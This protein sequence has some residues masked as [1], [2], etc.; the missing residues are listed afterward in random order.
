MSVDRL[1][2]NAF[3]T[4]LESIYTSVMDTITCDGGDLLGIQ[5][6]VL[7]KL[8][9]K[10][11]SAMPPAV[12]RLLRFA[13][14]L[15]VLRS[16]DRASLAQALEAKEMD[17]AQLPELHVDLLTAAWL[18]LYFLG[19]PFNDPWD[20]ARQIV[21]ELGG[22]PVGSCFNKVIGDVYRTARQIYIRDFRLPAQ[23]SAGRELTVLTQRA[24][25][26]A[27]IDFLPPVKIADPL[28][29]NLGRCY[30][31]LQLRLYRGGAADSLLRA[32]ECLE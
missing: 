24:I 2:W 20:R 21:D 15:A 19:L 18:G 14:T 31:W 13:E 7:G 11:E 30:S 22:Y 6:A 17:E 28:I 9:G 29:T 26:L 3:R 5:V 16:S 8:R 12:D 10:E 23:E 1:Q 27:P 32:Q 4:D 25:G